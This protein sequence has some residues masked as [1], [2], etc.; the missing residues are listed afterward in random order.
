V[1]NYKSPKYDETN[2]NRQGK[3]KEIQEGPLR[4]H[5]DFCYRC[6]NKDH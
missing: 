1:N 2:K 5:D 3:G 6:G 4:N